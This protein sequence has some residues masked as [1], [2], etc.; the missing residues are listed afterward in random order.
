MADSFLFYIADEKNISTAKLSYANNANYAI[1]CCNAQGP[2]MGDFL[3]KGGNNW[4]YYNVSVGLIYPKIGIP[5]R[6]MIDNYEV[7]QVIKK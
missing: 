3:C 6:F 1:F 5:E 4:R 7:F 2:H